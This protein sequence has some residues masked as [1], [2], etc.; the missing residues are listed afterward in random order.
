MTSG[1]R[2]NNVGSDGAR[3]VKG[4]I[5]MEGDAVASDGADTSGVLTGPLRTG[6]TGYG[7]KVAIGSGA[8]EVLNGRLGS[9]G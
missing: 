3:P 5:S 4:S 1:R 7:V 6:T 9:P 8:E 2:S